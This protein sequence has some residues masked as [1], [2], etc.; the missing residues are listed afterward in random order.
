[1]KISELRSRYHDQI[2]A[3]IVRFKT[4]NSGSSYPNFA[5][6]S[7]QAS[8][9]I[10]SKLL[11]KINCS[12]NQ[13]S[14]SAISQQQAGKIFEEIT[15]LFIIEAL[16]LIQHLR[17]AK[18]VYSIG[19]ITKFEQYT[20]LAELKRLS[21]K[22]KDLASAIGTDYIIKP[23]IVIGRNPVTDDEINKNI[24]L[25]DPQDRVVHYSPLRQRGKSLKP[26]LHAS[27]SCK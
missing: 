20:H 9:E 7:N 12:K 23:D 26:I 17:P 24:K 1:M 10:A 6:S 5:D 21:K 16:N 27:I 8:R 2:C 14:L 3:K 25:I 13:T 19:N 22:N 4:D 11:K 15:R 18:W